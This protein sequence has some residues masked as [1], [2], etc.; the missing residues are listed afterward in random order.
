M[1]CVALDPMVSEEEIVA[2]KHELTEAGADWHFLDTVICSMRLPTQA[3][4]P[5]LGTVYDA[6]TDRREDIAQNILE[7][8]FSAVKRR[9]S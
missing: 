2:L 3:N 9:D 5:E 8:S 6:I 7:E 1:F 4:D